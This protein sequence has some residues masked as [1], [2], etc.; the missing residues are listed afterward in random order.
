MATTASINRFDLL[1]VSETGSPKRRRQK[2][3]QGKGKLAL[4]QSV[5]SDQVEVMHQ[6]VLS[7][8]YGSTSVPRHTPASDLKEL[9]PVRELADMVGGEANMSPTRSANSDTEVNV[10]ASFFGMLARMKKELLDE[11]QE[12]FKTT[13]FGGVSFDEYQKRQEKKF[14]F[15]KHQ[16]ESASLRSIEDWCLTRMRRITNLT[17][18]VSHADIVDAFLSSYVALNMEPEYL[19]SLKNSEAREMTS[20][21]LH[22]SYSD[23]KV[24]DIMWDALVERLTDDEAKKYKALM[25]FGMGKIQV[26]EKQRS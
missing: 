1:S 9:T 11:L 16:S 4:N 17:S 7:E 24:V 26:K 23:Q 25:M 20:K 19:K 12:E 15:I 21:S 22:I 8:T 10:K 18:N 2:A 13:A 14:E 6:V 5:E 3:K